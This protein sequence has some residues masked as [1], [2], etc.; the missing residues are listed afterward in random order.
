M[1]LMIFVVD[2][3]VRVYDLN[4]AAA[5]LFAP[6]GASVLK[7][8]GGEVLHCLHATDVPGGCG[9]GPFCQTCVVRSS[10][11]ACLRGQGVTRRRTK[12]T[13]PSQRRRRSW[14]C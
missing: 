8:R 11:T 4:R 7:R 5:A 6:D 12:V 2:G 9:R 1:P 10:V 13:L 14:S 3:D